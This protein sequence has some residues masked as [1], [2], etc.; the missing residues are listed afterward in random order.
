MDP[1]TNAVKITMTRLTR[2]LG[3]PD[4]IHTIPGVGYRITKHPNGDSGADREA[5]P[6]CPHLL[7]AARAGFANAD[8]STT[9]VQHTSPSRAASRSVAGSAG[10][11]AP[12]VA[13]VAASRALEHECWGRRGCLRLLA[14]SFDG[15]R[16]L[17]DEALRQCYAPLVK[18]S[19]RCRPHASSQRSPSA[20]SHSPHVAPLP[21]QAVWSCRHAGAAA[22]R[23]RNPQIRTKKTAS[24]GAGHLRYLS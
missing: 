16:Q 22:P 18:V 19:A 15:P 2:K 8:G 20:L 4:I 24:S 14:C 10:R 7:L 23:A 3:Q 21:N 9:T 11:P 13:L 17:G 1:F 5:G 12:T 6:R